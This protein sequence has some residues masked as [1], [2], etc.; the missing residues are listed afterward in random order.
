MTAVP[1][2]FGQPEAA[3]TASEGAR[4][5]PAEPGPPESA[6]AGEAGT[7]G[8]AAGGAAPEAGEPAAGDWLAETEKLQAEK[9]RYLQMAQRI[10]A[11][12]DNYRKRAQREAAN[13]KR[14][15]LRGFL[16]DFLG[17]FDDLDRVLAEA[18]KEPGAA[19]FRQGAAM[20]RDNLWR[21]MARAGVA[22]IETRDA[23]FDPRFHE[24]IAAV[25]SPAHPA[26]TV[27]ETF[28]PGYRLDDFVLRAARVSVSA[29]AG[30]ETTES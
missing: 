22:E 1:D 21:A 7:A 10:Q 29:A 9:D 30:P 25:P 5:G 2:G 16:Q 24:A 13:Q 23:P 14:D 26:G 11:D 20:A 17:A 27:L 28:Q 4:D 18:A 3:A 8:T 15:A 19:V 12:F 6:P